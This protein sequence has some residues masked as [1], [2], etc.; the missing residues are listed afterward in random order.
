[1]VESSASVSEEF[2]G[3]CPYQDDPGYLYP[4]YEKAEAAADFFASQFSNS[5]ESDKTAVLRVGNEQV[6]SFVL[7]VPM[8]IISP[9]IYWLKELIKPIDSKKTPG[10][11]GI[12]NKALK[13]LGQPSR[14]ILL[15]IVIAVLRFQSFQGVGN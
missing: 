8:Q 2:H 4:E 14:E 1:M 11:D 3:E 6:N 7:N 5:Q 12:S 10:A 13:L 9:T 15:S